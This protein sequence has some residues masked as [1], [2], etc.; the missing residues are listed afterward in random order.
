MS[1]RDDQREKPSWREIDKKRDRPGHSPRRKD[2]DMPY[3]KD[4]K[5]D[6]YLKQVD[7]FFGAEKLSQKERAGL[8][9]MEKALGT[10]KFDAVV[11]KYVDK[12]GIPEDWN[13]LM[14]MLEYSDSEVVV[15]GVL[16]MFLKMYPERTDSEKA[17]LRYKLDTMA[18]TSDDPLLEA[19]LEG[20]LAKLEG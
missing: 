5:K 17:M 10:P 1:S 20:L 11:K 18:M 4:A 8:K 7:K 19:N 12:F 16:P 14:M 2:D 13:G 9:E 6:M 3:L 15:E